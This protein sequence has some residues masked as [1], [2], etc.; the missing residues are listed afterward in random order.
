M[1]LPR[2]KIKELCI[3]LWMWCMETG[4]RKEQWP[5]WG[6][7]GYI[8]GHCWFCYYDT[9]TVAGDNRI[10]GGY[11][12]YCPYREK[13]GHCTKPGNFYDHWDKAETP[14]TRKKYAKL[15]LEQIKQTV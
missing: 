5:R 1:R 4:K 2:G 9:H 10:G 12:T 7:F 6:E 3:E 14:R 13:F 11:C 15:F 8:H